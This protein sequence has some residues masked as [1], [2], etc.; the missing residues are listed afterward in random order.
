ME[1]PSA[2][3]KGSLPPTGSVILSRVSRGVPPELNRQ[4]VTPRSEMEFH[5]ATLFGYLSPNELLAMVLLA[6]IVLGVYLGLKAW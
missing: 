2:N 1:N 3:L 6:P 4:P 5:A